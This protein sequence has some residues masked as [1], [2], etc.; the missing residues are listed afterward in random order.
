MSSGI[1]LASPHLLQQEARDL[2]K[3][4]LDALLEGF[5]TGATQINFVCSH[6]S[7]SPFMHACKVKDSKADSARNVVH[8]G[9]LFSKLRAPDGSVHLRATC[10]D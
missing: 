5:D 7:T 10:C 1:D 8:M 4:I 6:F 9:H 2:D 3:S